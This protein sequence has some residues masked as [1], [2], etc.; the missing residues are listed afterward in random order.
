MK[1][2]AEPSQLPSPLSPPS[3]LLSARIR[4]KDA[5]QLKACENCRERKVGCPGPADADRGPCA[6]CQRLERTCVYRTRVVAKRKKRVEVRVK[7]LEQRIQELAV[8]LHSPL[9]D[10]QA[11][12]SITLQPISS[13]VDGDGLRTHRRRYSA[14]GKLSGTENT[15]QK[16]SSSL[17]TDRT[18]QRQPHHPPPFTEPSSGGIPPQE[19]SYT[20]RDR[21][22]LISTTEGVE[23]TTL[24][25][26][27]ER[28][29]IW[30]QHVS[31]EPFNGLRR[32]Q[33]Y[34]SEFLPSKSH[35]DFLPAHGK[36]DSTGDHHFK[37]FISIL[38]S[39][40]PAIGLHSSILDD[41]TI[42]VLLHWENHTVQTFGPP[43]MQ[44]AL[45]KHSFR[46]AGTAPYFLHLLIAF[47]ACHLQHLHGEDPR[48]ERMYTHHFELGLELY[49][50]A[51]DTELSSPVTISTIDALFA[52]CMT[53][54]LL[55][56]AMP[57]VPL[58]NKSTANDNDRN[59]PCLL[60]DDSSEDSYLT[61]LSWLTSQRGFHFLWFHPLIQPHLHETIWHEIFADSAA[62]IVE[63]LSLEISPTSIPNDW[64][65]LCNIDDS[66]TS[67]DPSNPYT[68]PLTFLNHALPLPAS[69][70]PNFP[71]F[72]SFAGR[73]LPEF[74]DLVR[75]RD[76]PAMLLL[77]HWL[78]KMHEMD[79]WWCADRVKAELQSICAWVSRASKEEGYKQGALVRRLLEAPMKMCGFVGG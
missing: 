18:S 61:H 59:P 48:L 47:T 24:L 37:Q 30:S 55:A 7:E 62:D 64:R 68:A 38:Q 69:H 8:Q 63:T 40:S 2:V 54:A 29:L 17:T 41:Q 25:T 9:L 75:N 44:E 77:A 22:V 73:V 56:Y 15:S 16:L 34:V 39:L 70:P 5:T 42:H 66:S 10:V 36:A 71:L 76:I 6:R 49:S 4:V 72:M 45:R 43:H 33:E 51:L 1:E 11:R 50:Q 31:N 14:T 12:Q 58:L 79:A 57:S 46:L 67:L 32:S 20:G 21:D 60:P 27:Q 13:T 28:T 26:L 74:I 53:I 65:I 52:G 23:V 78:T 3:E 19:M 35:L